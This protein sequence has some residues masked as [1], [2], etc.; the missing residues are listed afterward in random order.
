MKTLWFI[1][2]FCLVGSLKAQQPYRYE[3]SDIQRFWKA[4]D[5][6]STAKNTSDSLKIIQEHYLDQASPDFEEFLKRR[7]FKAEEYVKKIGLYPGFWESL[8]PMTL[9]ID[10]MKPEIDEVFRKLGAALPNFKQPDICFAIG[11]L[12]TGGTTS[13]N[14]ILIGADIAAADASIDK[15]EM[16]GW[17]ARV[18]GNTGDLVA[19]VAHETIHTQQHSYRK[20]TLLTGSV[21]EGVADFLTDLILDLN[22]NQSIH[23]YADAK[24]CELWKEFEAAMKAK[25]TNLRLWLY[26]GNQETDRPADLGYYMGYKIAEAYYEKAANKEQAVADLLNQKKYK[27]I[28]TRS[29]YSAQACNR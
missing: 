16:T 9:R 23:D 11:A 28:F 19:M 12:R 3:T 5:L 1:S 18:I 21:K 15:S 6:L 4:F 14:L 26:G 8:R 22:I 20:T 13:S 25:S 2:I 7:N 27:Q 24:E 29:N 17:L 10:S